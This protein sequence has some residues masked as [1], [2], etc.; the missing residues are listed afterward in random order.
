MT[1]CLVNDFK[2]FASR[3]SSQQSVPSSWVINLE[4]KV[5]VIQGAGMEMS[6]ALLRARSLPSR[7]ALCLALVLAHHISFNSSAL[8]GLTVC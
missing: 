2:G 3:C 5:V 7:A 6:P 8:Q 4:V 1:T